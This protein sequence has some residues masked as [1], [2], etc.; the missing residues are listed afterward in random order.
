MIFNDIKQKINEKDNRFFY[1]LLLMASLAFYLFFAFFDGAVICVDSPGYIG[2]H[3]SREP[4]YPMFLALFRFL[5]AGAGADFYLDVAALAQSLLAAV[6]SWSLIAYLSKNLRLGRAISFF[7]L[8]IPFAVSLLCRFAARRGSMY[9]NSILT[10]GIAISCYLLF[11]RFLF[12]Y[13]LSQSRK[14]LFLSCLLSFL[15]ISTRKQMIFSLVLVVLCILFVFF[16]KKA[17]IRG[18]AAAG[19]SAVCILLATAFLDLGYN[20]VL[21][22]E[23]V[24][25][26]GDTRFVTTMAFYTADRSDSD[27]LQ[28]EEIRNLFLEIYDIC[29][30]KEYLKHS[31]GRGWLSR[32][33]HFGDYYDCIQIDTMYPMISQY[34]MEKYGDDIVDLNTRT[35]QIMDIINA[36][37]IP[38]NIPAILGTFLDNILSGLITTVAQRNSLLIWYS[39]LIYVF[40]LVLLIWHIR[41][42]KNRKILL[43]SVLTLI[44]VLLNVGLV[45]LVIFCQTRYTIYNMAL[46]YISL[47]LMISEPLSGILKGRTHAV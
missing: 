24:R 32:V 9:S 47:I 14:S 1:L 16:R 45:S 42:G 36:S 17:L 23:M 10:E 44:S 15:L 19:I 20:Y 46:F 3:L 39:L 2:M 6:S 26:S 5:F 25:H 28:D 41:H 38:H 12:E 30:E 34:A 4:L 29:D 31:A 33:S 7:L 18:L 27:Y 11:F 40:Y 21:R 22:G 13:A 43:F 35:D 37:V 8:C